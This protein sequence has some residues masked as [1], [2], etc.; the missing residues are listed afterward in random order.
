M[1]RNTIM[2][3]QMDGWMDRT[4]MVGWKQ[5]DGYGWKQKQI[6]GWMDGWIEKNIDGWL[7][8]YS[9]KF[10]MISIFNIP[11]RHTKLIIGW[12]GKKQKDSWMDSS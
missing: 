8:V 1:D 7:D 10:I 3:K 5:S 2:K 12:T 11:I 9:I 6:D 4:K